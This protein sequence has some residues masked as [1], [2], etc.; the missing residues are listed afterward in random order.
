MCHVDNET[1]MSCYQHNITLQAV[2][3]RLHG[4]YLTEL[5]FALCI[6]LLYKDQIMDFFIKN[7]E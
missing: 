1:R 4:I 6:Y 5:A 2:T 7:D 3:L